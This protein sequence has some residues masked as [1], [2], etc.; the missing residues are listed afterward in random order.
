MIGAVEEIKQKDWS[1]GGR[2]NN[3]IGTVEEDQTTGLEQWRKIK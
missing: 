1:S 2:S 3:R